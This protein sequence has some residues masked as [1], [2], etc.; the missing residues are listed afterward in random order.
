MRADMVRK[1]LEKP[2]PSRELYSYPRDPPHTS[3]IFISKT[4]FKT[5]VSSHSLEMSRIC[6][7]TA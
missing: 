7:H 3:Q 2:S 4:R 1:L 5:C 6:F